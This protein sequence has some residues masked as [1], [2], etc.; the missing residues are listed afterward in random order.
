MSNSNFFPEI[1]PVN[2]L[3]G[4]ST[5]DVNGSGQGESELESPINYLSPTMQNDK[6]MNS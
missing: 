2:N 5:F 3:R 1:A 4:G 6:H